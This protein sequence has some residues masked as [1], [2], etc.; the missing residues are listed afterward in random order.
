MSN[1]H[2]EYQKTGSGSSYR[3]PDKK[4]YRISQPGSTLPIDPCQM[5]LIWWESYHNN[6]SRYSILTNKR[7]FKK[8]AFRNFFKRLKR[9]FLIIFENDSLLI[10]IGVITAMI[11]GTVVHVLT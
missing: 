7:S 1:S 2:A 5:K 4:E 3:D 9:V 11:I 8:Y 6:M 10:L